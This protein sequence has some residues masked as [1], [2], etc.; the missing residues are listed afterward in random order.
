LLHLCMLNPGAVILTGLSMTGLLRSWNIQNP[1]VEAGWYQ[2]YS[3]ASATRITYLPAKHWNRRGLRDM[4]TMLW[5]SF[6][7]EQDGKHIYFGADSG[8]GMHF[9]EIHA[10]YPSIDYALLGIGACEPYWF[11]H[12]AHTG[13]EE[14]LMAYADLGAT[15]MIPMHYG[16]F[17]LS[18]E[19][20]WYP[21]E[22]LQQL[23]AEKGI[24]GI[25]YPPIGKKIMI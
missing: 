9:K 20:I 7:I 5:G 17:D 13:P 15:H 19:P 11:M 8:L 21:G 23:Q 14:A 24:A 1:I 3:I 10:L 6:M 12:T 16:T 22:Q 4:N 25:Q 2:S 18:N